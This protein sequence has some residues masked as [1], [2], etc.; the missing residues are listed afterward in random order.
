MN[1]KFAGGKGRKKKN[2]ARRP[3]SEEFYAGIERRIGVT[4]SYLDDPS[5]QAAKSLRHVDDYL[6]TGRE[7]TLADGLDSILIFK[8]IQSELDKA[9]ERSARARAAAERRRH[10]R[11][12]QRAEAERAAAAPEA[13]VES[14]VPEAD[15]PEIDGVAENDAAAAT[16]VAA[17]ADVSAVEAGLCAVPS[18][19]GGSAGSEFLAVPAVGQRGTEIA[20]DHG[21]D[22]LVEEAGQVVG[23][24]QL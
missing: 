15:A 10:V 21:V 20:F 3:V 11:E 5:Q 4:V 14:A 2:G 16:V 22:I 6:A 12:L 9:K 23:Q 1:K 24:R 18:G 13:A 19:S 8:M 17:V 7:P